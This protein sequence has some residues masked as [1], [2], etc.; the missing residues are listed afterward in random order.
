L[1]PNQVVAFLARLFAIWLGVSSAQFAGLGVS[2]NGESLSTQL[3]MLLIAF[4][5]ALVA[6]LIWRYPMVVAHK[7]TQDR[8]P[9]KSILVTGEAA[10]V[11]CIVL[12]LWLFVA[13]V[14]PALMRELSTVAFLFNQGSNLQSLPMR[15]LINL[16][17]ALINLCISWVLVFRARV[18]SSYLLAIN[19]AKIS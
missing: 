3:T 7:L 1:S 16:L 10:L 6:I 9:S 5:M 4:A 14:L 8:E 12:G 19:K 13:S 11:A 15:E 18:V 17:I 2:L